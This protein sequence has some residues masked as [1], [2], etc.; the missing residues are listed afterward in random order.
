M[1]IKDKLITVESLKS[2][3]NEIKSDLSDYAEQLDD[4]IA[5]IGAVRL[6]V[7]NNLVIGT[8]TGG[9]GW[10][11]TVT[12]G[13]THTSGYANNASISLGAGAKN[14]DV[15]IVEFDTSYTDGEFAKIGIGNSYRN[16]A[17]TGNSHIVMPFVFDGNYN[18]RIT[19]EENRTFTLTNISVRKIESN[20]EEL[21][22][23]LDS[24]VSGGHDNNYG[25][26]N[27]LLGDRTLEKSSGSTRTIA[28][29]YGSLRNL[30]GGHRNIAL[31]TYSMSELSGGEKNTSIGADSMLSVKAG[32]EN[33]AIGFGALHNGKNAT[34]NVAIGVNA[35]NSSESGT[36]SNNIAIGRY[37]GYKTTSELNTM[38]G[39]QAGYRIESGTNNVCLGVNAYGGA[40]GNYNICIGRD[41]KY[42]TG[43]NNSIS[44]GRDATATASGQMV[45][46]SSLITDVIIA[47]KRITFNADGSVSWSAV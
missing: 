38:I 45:L 37:A 6:T 11:G 27:I 32:E 16:Y 44:I 4:T 22:L 43:V 33:V 19:P 30:Q 17:Y 35:L 13:L 26:W 21:N 46:G 39:Y 2:V 12:T 29:G 1:E 40:S 36:P 18:L 15:V 8:H 23:L 47:G 34:G 14:G 20:G 10:S 9:E 25:F 31:G 7:G 41:S 3:Y 42:N 24:I 28:I 5:D